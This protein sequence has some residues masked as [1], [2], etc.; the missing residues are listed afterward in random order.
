MLQLFLFSIKYMLI[1]LNINVNFNC[2]FPEFQLLL[3]EIY[4]ERIFMTARRLCPPCNSLFSKLQLPL[5]G[6]SSILKTEIKHSHTSFIAMYT[7]YFL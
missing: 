1:F 6:I 4:Q 5:T 2:I 3:S 7:T